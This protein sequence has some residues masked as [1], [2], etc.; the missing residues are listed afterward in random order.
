MRT[1]GNS[2]QHLVTSLYNGGAPL[3]SI[4]QVERKVSPASFSEVARALCEDEDE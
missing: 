2:L 4:R 1:L 3:A